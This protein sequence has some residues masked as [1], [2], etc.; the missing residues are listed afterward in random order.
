MSRTAA[1]PLPWRRP[2]AV[3]ALAWA[4][5]LTLF[6]RDAADMARIWWDS[7]TFNHCLLMVPLIGWL[8]VQRWPLLRQLTP[9]PWAPA[10]LAAL[11]AALLWLAGDVG[12]VGLFRQAGLVAMLIS[13][14][15]GLLGPK[16]GRA[17]MFPLFYM[18][19]LVPFGEEMVPALQ[20]LTAKITIAMIGW[21]GI[22]AHIDGVFITT[23]GGFFEVAEAC[24]GVK[25][26]IAMIA[27]AALAANLCFKSWWR[28]AAFMVF[29]AVTAI[30]AN[31][32][33]AFGTIYI[34]EKVDIGFAASFDHIFY[35][36]V[37]FGVVI[38]IVMGAAWKFFDRPADDPPFDLA[39]LA[40]PVTRT[41][42]WPKAAG[43]LGT[44][45]ALPLGW[46]M[47][48]GAR[49]GALPP[50]LVLDAPPGWMADTAAPQA[51]WTPRFDGAE[52]TVQRR[53]R[54]GRGQ[55]V[56][57]V[58]TAFARQAEGREIV[59]FGQGSDARWT[60]AAA[61]PPIA[62]G[63]VDR[64]FHPGPVNRDAAIWYRLDG[65][66]TA[67]PA[68]AKLAG[69]KA[70]L[71]GGDPRAVALIISAEDYPGA[72]AR[73]AIAAFAKSA[74]PIDQMADRAIQIR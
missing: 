54:N 56:D 11:G 53:Y 73:D 18:T 31:G 61:A 19:L 3:L 33:R 39:A 47:V 50:S 45:I 51:A 24:S 46:G 72:P 35:G 67:S 65:V 10:S 14:V 17:L 30:V 69:I 62:G 27:Y 58:I 41:L 44:A 71:L 8:V 2:L 26:L 20:T 32:I 37:F 40:G 49:A 23:P 57:V 25:F 6:A 55:Q 42:T 13:A 60:W 38:L 64:M 74:G 29:A 59:G 1:I 16:A 48:T 66:T 34:A 68:R 7:S 21:A 12:G 5:L 52:R 4:A 15:V 36:W 9:A 28:R 70:R 22:P 43:L 63:R